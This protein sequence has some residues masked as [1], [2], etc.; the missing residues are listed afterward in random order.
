[1]SEFK[2]TLATGDQ[3]LVTDT[4]RSGNGANEACSPVD[5]TGCT[6]KFLVEGAGVEFAKPATVIDAVNG[7][8]QYRFQAGDT[9]VAGDYTGE[10]QVT[11]GAGNVVTHPP[12]GFAFQIVPAIP[13]PGVTQFALLSDLFDDI[14][15]LTGDF[16]KRLYQ[17]SAIASVMRTQLR[18]GRVKTDCG[19]QGRKSWTVGAD[20][21]SISPP[22]Q[23]TDVQA[24]SL[25]VYNTALA[26]ITPNIAA[27]SYRTRALSERFGE[28]RDFLAELKNTLYEL[29]NDE[30]WANITG[31]R[32]WLFA[33]NGV[34]VWS[35]MQAEDNIDLSFH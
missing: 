2:F 31:L 9:N 24:Y 14:R 11:D 10:W 3:P 12:E 1:M 29:E 25:L 5:L 30:A 19:H 15:A 27:Y 18:L 17:D 13:Q 26:L 35:Y 33:V 23:N 21:Q 28:A 34:W 16:K 20:G 7:R 22:I 32:S 4:I 8:V 6:V